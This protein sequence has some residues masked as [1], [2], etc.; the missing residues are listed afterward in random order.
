MARSVC[1]RSRLVV[2]AVV[3][4][5]ASAC[6][7][8][9][10]AAADR[11]DE[12]AVTVTNLVSDVPGRAPLTDP[13]LSNAWGLAAGPTSP[14][15]VAD[16]HTDVSTLYSGAT[17]NQ[18][19][20]KVPLTV[21]IA[22]GA[23]TGVVFSSGAGFVVSDGTTSGPARFIFASEGGDI[24]GWNPAVPPP[25]PSTHSQPAVHVADAVYK[26]LAIAA[27]PDGSRL[28]A[29]NFH[30]GTI[31]VFDDTFAAVR[32]F[33]AFVDPRLP[34]GY[35]PFDVAAVD[36]H[37]YVTYALQDAAAHDDV[38]GRG[39]GFIDVYTFDGTLVRR[40]VSRGRL[41]SPWGLSLAPS[42]FGR[43]AGMLLVGN[44]GDGRINV[45]DPM[46]GRFRGVVRDAEGDPIVIDGLWALQIGNPTI[47]GTDSVLFSAGPDGEQHGLFGLLRADADD[48]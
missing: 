21:S 42:S 35:A 30:A 37:L 1:R 3:G 27:T 23:P 7:G 4:V 13:D 15:W 46:T 16:N 34:A 12:V 29:A 28:F 2:A 9:G 36:G 47:G 19:V 44:F 40:L 24:T 6:V 41:D 22:G 14:I 43:F 25:P 17:G 39:H 18:P 45:Y 11:G 32:Q 26:G 31:D 33:G 10:P 38:K 5:V 8:V 48:D 20:A